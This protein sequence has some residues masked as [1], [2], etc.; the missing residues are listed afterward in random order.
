[1][2]GF[3]VKLNIKVFA[4]TAFKYAACVA[5]Q[6]VNGGCLS[7]S[8]LQLGEY[9]CLGLESAIVSHKVCIF[10]TQTLILC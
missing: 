4:M 6:A 10:V 9:P 5:S 7:D 3:F 1:M 2:T 8:A